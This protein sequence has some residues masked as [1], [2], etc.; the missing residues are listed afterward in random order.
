MPGEEASQENG[1][2]ICRVR[3]IREVMCGET[4]S[5][6]DDYSSKAQ[7]S[8]ESHFLRE[9]LCG[10]QMPSGVPEHPWDWPAGHLSSAPLRSMLP[11][12]SPCKSVGLMLRKEPL[13]CS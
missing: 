8:H 2:G 5:R 11:L 1:T 3:S 9:G 7:Y 12:I 6:A 13:F 4:N 10:L